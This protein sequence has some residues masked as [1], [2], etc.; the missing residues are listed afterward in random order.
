M[1]KKTAREEDKYAMISEIMALICA[2]NVLKIYKK[3][4]NNYSLDIQIFAF[5]F[6]NVRLQKLLRCKCKSFGHTF[7]TE[8]FVKCQ[9][10]F[11]LCGHL[12]SR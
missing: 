6:Y 3:I 2:Q 9:Y 1:S 12:I 7:T 4:V 5:H 8:I 11:F 10:Y